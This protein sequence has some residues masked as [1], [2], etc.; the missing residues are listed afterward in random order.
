MAPE[1]AV[2]P[3]VQA[4]H[5]HAA[6]TRALGHDAA[7]N[8]AIGRLAEPDRTL[9]GLAKAYLPRVWT[10]S[11]GRPFWRAENTRTTLMLDSEAAL[12]LTDPGTVRAVL[13]ALV[14]ERGGDPGPCGLAAS[15]TRLGLGPGEGWRLRDAGERLYFLD[16]RDVVS[17]HLYAPEVA[18]E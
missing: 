16:R 6:L 1:Q 12:D 3:V 17:N 5:M 14:L 10:L 8:P 2:A 7:D 13:T 4:R 15:W 11:T 9:Q 18:H